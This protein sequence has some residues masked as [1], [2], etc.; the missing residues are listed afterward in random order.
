MKTWKLDKKR[1]GQLPIYQFWYRLYQ[2]VPPSIVPL[3]WFVKKIYILSEFLYGCEIHPNSSIGYGLYLGHPWHITINGK[4]KIGRNCNIH[5]NVTIGQE[6]R[7]KRVGA[8]TIGDCVWIG[9][10]ATVVGNIKIGNDVM[11][12]P[13]SF[14]N[15]DVPDHSIV[16]G[17]PCEIRHK[18]N[19]TEGYIN[20]CIC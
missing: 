9:V 14:V 19:A 3:K 16:F 11:I 18:Q 13:N 15:C 1:K 2:S 17:N 10:N 6:S 12:A 20:D 7:G 4:A 8:P 5:K